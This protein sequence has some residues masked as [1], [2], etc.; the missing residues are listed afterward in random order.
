M[1]ELGFVWPFQPEVRPFQ[2]QCNKQT[3]TTKTKTSAVSLVNGPPCQDHPVT[4]EKCT[5]CWSEPGS[6]LK[7]WGWDRERQVLPASKKLRKKGQS[8]QTLKSVMW[9]LRAAC[10]I[11][12]SSASSSPPT[13][14][15]FTQ[16]NKQRDEIIGSVPLGLSGD[17]IIFQILASR[18]L[19]GVRLAHRRRA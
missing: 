14:C 8:K 7:A 5:E 17:F 13:E 3:K 1:K 9:Q 6:L 10:M 4:Q 2:T 19:Q 16:L 18:S 11:E 15:Q 12:L